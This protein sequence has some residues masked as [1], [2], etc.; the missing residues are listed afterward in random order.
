MIHDHPIF[1]WATPFPASNTEA[2][3]R[4][5]KWGAL[6]GASRRKNFFA[7]PLH[8]YAVPPLLGARTHPSVLMNFDFNHD[9][10]VEV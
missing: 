3:E 2:P 8:F 5:Y 10:N 4:F 6:S 1:P 7:V 9:S